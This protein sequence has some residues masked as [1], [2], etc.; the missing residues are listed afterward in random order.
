VKEKIKELLPLSFPLS[1]FFVC[2]SLEWT[3][4]RREQRRVQICESLEERAKA[5]IY[6]NFQEL[7]R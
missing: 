6:L 7:K 5:T 1:F 4:W 3:A 2:L